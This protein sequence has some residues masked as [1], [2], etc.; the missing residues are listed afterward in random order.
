MIKYNQYGI[1]ADTNGYTVGVVRPRI[2]D[3]KEEEYLANAKYY[4]DLSSAIR[5]LMEFE[6][7]RITAES[8]T[9]GDLMQAVQESDKAILEALP[10]KIA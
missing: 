5:G 1:T 2:K 4:G 10:I 8:Q 7:R 6:R 3:G 9:L